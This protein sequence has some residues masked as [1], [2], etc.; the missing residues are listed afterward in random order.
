MR[1]CHTPNFVYSWINAYSCFK[2][3]RVHVCEVGPFVKNAS[4]VAFS[5]KNASAGNSCS[6]P[7]M[8]CF[9]LLLPILFYCKTS[10]K[11]LKMAETVKFLW[12]FLA[13]FTYA[14]L[15]LAYALLPTGVD[16]Y[17][18]CS[19]SEK[20]VKTAEN[21]LKWAKKCL[22]SSFFIKNGQKLL[23]FSQKLLSFSAPGQESVNFLWETVNFFCET[24]NFFISHSKSYTFLHHRPLL[25]R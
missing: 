18:P 23:S 8:P 14:L 3:I 12:S 16:P 22:F 15:H 5:T 10:Q 1:A 6:R 2:I 13:S 19:R 9:L 25:L 11:G 17:M 7:H 4:A 24:V 20:G 21:G